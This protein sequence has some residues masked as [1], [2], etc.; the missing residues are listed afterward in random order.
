MDTQELQALVLT[1][2]LAKTIRRRSG[3]AGMFAEPYCLL[4][5]GLARVSPRELL[6]NW[7]FGSQDTDVRQV[8]TDLGIAPL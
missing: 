8:L 6:G 3:G 2:P 1:E 4:A 7:R 5:Y